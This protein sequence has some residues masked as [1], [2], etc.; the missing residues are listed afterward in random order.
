MFI[1]IVLGLGGTI[2]VV[3]IIFLLVMISAHLADI[4]AELNGIKN[5]LERMAD[6]QE[7]QFDER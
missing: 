1:K 7:C 5:A 3:G 4:Y 2:A 6:V